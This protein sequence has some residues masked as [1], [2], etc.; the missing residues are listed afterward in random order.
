MKNEI[1]TVLGKPYEIEYVDE[2]RSCGTMGCADRGNQHIMINQD[3]GKDQIAETILH[4]I[5]H[6]I[7]QELL[8]ELKEETVARLA[9]GLYSAGYRR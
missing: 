5:I 1:V 8:L 2:A 7:D 4:E 9:V 3:N 6:I